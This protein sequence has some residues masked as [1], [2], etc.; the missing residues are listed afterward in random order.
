[1]QKRGTGQNDLQ[2]QERQDPD[3]ITV[4]QGAKYDTVIN[5]ACD[6]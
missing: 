1:M 4:R 6:N 3:H 2:L 5:E